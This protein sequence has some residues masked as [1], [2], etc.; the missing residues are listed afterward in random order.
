M[1]AQRLVCLRHDAVKLRISPIHILNLH[2]RRL[3]KLDILTPRCVLTQAVEKLLAAPKA[4]GFDT[5]LVPA[6]GLLAEE[7][8]LASPG[9]AIEK[10]RA[11]SLTH[12]RARVAEA[13]EP[14]ADWRRASALDCK[15]RDCAEFARFLDD[16]VQTA[17]VL[18]AAESPE[19]T[20]HKRSTPRVVTST[21]RPNAKGT[22]LQLD[23]YEKS[24]ELRPPR[25]ATQERPREYFD[26]TKLSGP[27]RSRAVVV[28][29]RREVQRTRVLIVL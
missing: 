22:P 25:R 16:P 7:G 6:L 29:G 4:F 8:T 28:P 14:P 26:D 15:C 27:A 17:F 18:R 1:S 11:A 24:G 2:V 10:L 12:L 20:S 19:P 5:V 23:L 9:V 3:A 13:L 21:S